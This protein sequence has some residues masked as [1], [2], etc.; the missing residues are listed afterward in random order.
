MFA[1]NNN[2]YSL[3]DLAA[4]TGNGNRNNGMF[5][6]E[7]GAW[8]IIILFLFCFAGWGGNGGLFGGGNSTGSGIT[9]GYILTSDFASLE[10]Q[11]ENGFDRIIN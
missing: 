5:G 4:V 7:G 2:G 11:I 1:N 9:D 3:S 10:R 8:W 6:D